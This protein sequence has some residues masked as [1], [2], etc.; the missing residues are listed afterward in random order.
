M[1]SKCLQICKNEYRGLCYT[2]W[3]FCGKWFSIEICIYYIEQSRLWNVV[4]EWRELLIQV[5][6][7]TLTKSCTIFAAS[8]TQQ[9]RKNPEI[10]CLLLDWNTLTMHLLLEAKSVYFFMVYTWLR[11]VSRSHLV[12]SN[13]HTS[14]WFWCHFLLCNYAEV[15]VMWEAMRKNNCLAH[16]MAYLK[17]GESK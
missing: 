12:L 1:F 11:Q 14:L 5:L 8:D 4:P 13:A 6:F 16:M 10:E 7:T 2:P 9:K 15:L 3:E 17:V